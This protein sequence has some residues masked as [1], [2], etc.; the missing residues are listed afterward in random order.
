MPRGRKDMLAACILALAVLGPGSETVREERADGTVVEREIEVAADGTVV[1]EGSHRE[2]WPRGGR[3]V[4]GR[5]RAGQ[6]HG[7][8]REWHAGGGE[9]VTGWYERGLRGRDWTVRAPDGSLVEDESGRF[10]VVELGRRG[11][12]RARGEARVGVR[13]GRWSFLWPHGGTQV[14]CSYR[15]GVLTGPL[16]LVHADGTPD[17]RWA[18]G[19]YEADRRRRALSDRERA[20]LEALCVSPGAGPG[21]EVGALVAALR[22]E[23]D[24]PEP[25]RQAGRALFELALD[26]AV[27][28]EVVAA[29]DL[30]RPD[31]AR[32]ANLIVR[33]RVL[34]VYGVSFLWT[35]GERPPDLDA[36]ALSPWSQ[37]RW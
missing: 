13:H 36:F 31:E 16:L 32:L 28:P 7:K 14:V 30:E 23:A 35:V 11:A 37:R 3:K 8:W 15:E 12:L 24:L 1:A 18:S 10:E 27:L 21:G 25:E 29:L 5:Y 17:P 6:R 4:D 33:E 20:A 9:A 19:F 26:D 34:P 2:W 22:A